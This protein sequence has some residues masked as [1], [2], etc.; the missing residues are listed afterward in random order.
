[1]YSELASVAKKATG[2]LY[3]S[4]VTEFPSSPIAHPWEQEQEEDL[5]ALPLAW[6]NTGHKTNV[7]GIGVVSGTSRGGKNKVKS[8]RLTGA[9]HR[10]AQ[11][12]LALMT[13]AHPDE[14]LFTGTERCQIHQRSIET[15]GWFV[16]RAPRD[17]PWGSAAPALYARYNQALRHMVARCMAADP[18][19]RPAPGP[20][21][22]AVRRSVAAGDA[23]EAAGRSPPGESDADL[24]AFCRAFFY[25]PVGPPYGDPEEAGGRFVF[26]RLPGG[27]TPPPQAGPGYP[28]GPQPLAEQFV[29]PRPMSGLSHQSRAGFDHSP[30]HRSMS[31]LSHQSRAGGDHS[32]VDE[33][34]GGLSPGCRG[35][36]QDQVMGGT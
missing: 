28:A 2:R 13:R 3:V 6:D 17:I 12:M 27:Q 33:P 25:S 32:P 31:G 23:A 36:D 24:A 29:F 10:L 20:L 16:G 7:W 22:D 4:S 21:L 30:A 1:M 14:T 35:N 34:M 19:D 8:T 5:N 15:Y 9:R 18:A 26:P 11:T